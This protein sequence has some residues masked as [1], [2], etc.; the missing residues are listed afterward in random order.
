MNEEPKFICCVGAGPETPEDIRFRMK[1][2]PAPSPSSTIRS[3]FETRSADYY[4]YG[5]EPKYIEVH[6]SIIEDLGDSICLA[7]G[8]TRLGVLPKTFRKEATLWVFDEPNAVGRF[9]LIEI[10]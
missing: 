5:L 4:D 8:E 1:Q 6:S 2:V 10:K 7:G 9:D 3:W